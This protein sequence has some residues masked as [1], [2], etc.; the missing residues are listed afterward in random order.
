M[1][2]TLSDAVLSVV[3]I[4]NER[5]KALQKFFNHLFSFSCTKTCGRLFYNR[6]V[7]LPSL[8]PIRTHTHTRTHTIQ[9]RVLT[10]RTW[11]MWDNNDCFVENIFISE[12]SFTGNINFY[13]ISELTAGNIFLLG[14]YTNDLTFTVK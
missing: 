2:P 3:P 6:A 10:A 7:G 12:V 1:V 4:R 9:T 8:S 5:M 11:F 13:C 14:S